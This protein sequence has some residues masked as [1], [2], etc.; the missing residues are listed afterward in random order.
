MYNN[1][2]TKILITALLCTALYT[3]NAS[4]SGVQDGISQRSELSQFNDL[5]TRTGVNAT[6]S[7][8]T[9]T[10]F[11]PINEAFTPYSGVTYPYLYSGEYPQFNNIA[12]T[13][14]QNH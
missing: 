14:A 10:V 12:T 11:A 13:I 8:G 9:H 1:S 7:S 3:A 5:L 2:K 4:A 6:L